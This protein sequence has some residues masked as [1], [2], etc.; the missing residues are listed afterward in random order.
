MLIGHPGS[1]QQ[2]QYRS[3]NKGLSVMEMKSKYLHEQYLFENELFNLQQHQQIIRDYSG[4]LPAMI[5]VDRD[6]Q[7]L[8]QHHVLQ[9]LGDQIQKPLMAMLRYLLLGHVFSCFSSVLM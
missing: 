7:N 2:F 4:A 9:L 1:W 6:F 3:D 8:V 5:D